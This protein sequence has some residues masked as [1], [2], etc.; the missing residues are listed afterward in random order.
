MVLRRVE[1]LLNNNSPAILAGIGIVGTITTAYLTGQ[2]SFKAADI[3]QHREQEDGPSVDPWIRFKT[4]FQMVWKL[5]LPAVGSATLT[6]G[7]VVLSNRIS[8][9]R[10]VAV[11]AAYSLTEKAFSEYRDKV[12]EKFGERKEQNVREELAQDRI[13]KN[14][15]SNREVVITSGEVLCYETFTGRYFT[16]NVETLRKAQNDLNARI[17]HDGHASLSEFYY[18]LGLPTTS[19][20]DNVGWNTD[21]LLELDISATLSEDTRPCLAVSYVKPPVSN[22]YTFH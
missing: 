20:S 12:I 10:A 11:A 16:S 8:E 9:R 19:I 3:I 15:V 6:V 13:T 2:A 17:L 4:R 1:K 22:Y 5:Y 18:S 7:A 14:P 21:K